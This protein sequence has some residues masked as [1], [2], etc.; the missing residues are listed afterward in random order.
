MDC[1]YSSETHPQHDSMCSQWSR[2]LLRLGYTMFSLVEG[3]PEGLDAIWSEVTCPAF[4]C[5]WLS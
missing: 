4:C 1:S 5:S 2:S 3:G